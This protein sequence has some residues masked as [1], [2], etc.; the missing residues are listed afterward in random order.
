LRSSFCLAA[1]ALLLNIEDN[2]NNQIERGAITEIE[3]ATVV[4]ED[5][6]SAI[7]EK[8]VIDNAIKVATDFTPKYQGSLV[9]DDYIVI[10]KPIIPRR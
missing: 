6:G 8:D 4:S 5:I 3:D 10:Y 2:G 9:S 1:K 7:M